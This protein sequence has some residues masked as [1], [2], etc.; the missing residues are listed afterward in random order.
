[1][2]PLA[3]AAEP[4]MAD[5]REPVMS[6]VDLDLDFEHFPEQ[7]RAQVPGFDRIY[8]QHVRYYDQVLPHV[9][10]GD[11]VRFLRAEVRCHG[12]GREALRQATLLLERGM[13]SADSKLRELVAVSFLA[14]LDPEDEVCEALR[15]AGRLLGA[16][17]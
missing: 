2:T 9:L 16:L 12:E 15:R 17:L 13:E 6:D 10:L 1:M 8:D 4:V 5:G 3:M 14:K 11:L 7:L